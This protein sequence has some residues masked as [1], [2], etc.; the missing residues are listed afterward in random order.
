M[1][2]VPMSITNRHVDPRRAHNDGYRRGAD[3][4]AIAGRYWISPSSRPM[5]ADISR[6]SAATRRNF[7]LL[8]SSGAA[9]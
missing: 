9:R 4:G 7:F 8:K 1:A 5:L 2:L 3:I 6:L